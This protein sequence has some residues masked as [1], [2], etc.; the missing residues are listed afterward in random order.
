MAKFLVTLLILIFFQIPFLFSGEIYRWTDDRGATHFTDD[1]SKIPEQYTDRAE[2]LKVQ[3]EKLEEVEKIEKQEERSDRVK[4]YLENVEKKIEMKKSME[5]KVSELEEEL[6]LSEE[7][8][9]WIEEYEREEYYYNIPFRDPKTGRWVPVA[10]PYYGE[11]RRLKAKINDL[12]AEIEGIQQRLSQ[13]M[14]G[15]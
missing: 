9:K 3:E 4:D 10:S 2:K 15:L 1:L 12:K 11:K 6:R 5:K 7:R 13:L 14:R 8:L